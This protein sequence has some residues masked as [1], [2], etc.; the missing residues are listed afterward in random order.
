MTW[1]FEDEACAYGD[2]AL[3]QLAVGATAVVP[4]LW[5]SEVANVLLVAERR[6]RLTKRKADAFVARLGDLPI[7][8]WDGQAVFGDVLEI[9]RRHSLTA[10]DATY[11]AMAN[12]LA[13]PVA[14]L[15]RGLI[16]AL[17]ARVAAF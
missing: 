16:K 17:G 7:V 3:D 13:L 5:L 15:D 4:Q 10:Y 11:V 6:H 8:V 1:C 14:T 2:K 9:G 12:Q